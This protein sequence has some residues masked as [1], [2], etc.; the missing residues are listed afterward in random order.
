MPPARALPALLAAL[1]VAFAAAGCDIGGEGGGRPPQFGGAEEPEQDQDRLAQFALVSV[2][3]TNTTRLGGADAATDAAG[4]ASAVF[5]ATGEETRPNAVL[6][7]DERDWQAGIAGAVLSGGPIAAPALVSSGEDLP[8]VTE[9]TLRRLNPKGSD[10]A[11]D[12]QVIAL[13]A[14]PPAPEGFR[15]TRI[16]GRDPYELADAIA[17]FSARVRGNKASRRVIV[18]SGEQPDFAMPAA[19][20]AARSGDP[21]LF[22]RRDVLP[23]PT[24]RAL[25]RHRKPDV[26]L[27]GPES[28]VS[29]DVE[30][31]LRP[32]ARRVRRI[33]GPTP[34][35]NAIAFARYRAGG[36]GWGITVPGYQFTVASVSRPLDAA[37]AAPLA[38]NGIFA[39]LLV[40][41]RAE[42][43]PTPLENYLLDV[44][45]G[46]EDDPRNAVYN[47]VWILGDATALGAPA[48]SR[49]DEIARL[50][51]VQARPPGPTA[52]RAR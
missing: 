29:Q 36:F 25:G 42:P 10:L 22:T 7:A 49:L 44:R 45:P 28:I 9:D 41:D 43:L 4:V 17:A 47:R 16:E 2:S 48:Q 21:V 46:Y 19:A 30:R 51:P 18:A 27:L 1:L 32:L 11:R 24:K 12:A 6:L 39:P 37:A 38:A 40:T 14:R 13:G 34:V 35:T 15:L 8:D 23:E 20:W 5:P 31:A 52:A 50:I 3:T 26:F 33:E